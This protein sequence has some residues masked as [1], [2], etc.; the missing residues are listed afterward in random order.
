[1]ARCYYIL[2]YQFY[3]RCD[4]RVTRGVN[5]IMNH[6]QEWAGRS[7]IVLGLAKSGVAVAKLLHRLGANVLVNEL[8]PRSECQGAT[9][10]ET[11]G[12]PVLCGGHPDDLISD[13]VDLV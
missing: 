5:E 8:K 4:R 10:L 6:S 2:V 13:E 11:L 9:E 12:I 7:V 3:S 1:M